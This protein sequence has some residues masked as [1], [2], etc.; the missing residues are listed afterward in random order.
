MRRR[1]ARLYWARRPLSS[2]MAKAGLT[3]PILTRDWDS[4][5]TRALRLASCCSYAAASCSTSDMMIREL[6]SR[7]WGE[8]VSTDRDI[9]A[10]E[11]SLNLN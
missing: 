7:V 10:S 4:L 9:E 6:R 11:K 2:G 1:N 8:L 5:S 3:R